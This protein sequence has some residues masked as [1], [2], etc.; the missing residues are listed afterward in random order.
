MLG[1]PVHGIVAL[2]TGRPHE[3]PGPFRSHQIHDGD[4]YELRDGHAVH[5]MTASE[6]HG[7][8]NLVGGRVLASDPAVAGSVGVDVGFSFNDGKNLRAP[9]ISTGVG[10]QP[11]WMR[12]AP[13]LAVEY[14]GPGQDEVE[15]Q[16]KIHE[17]LAAG[18]RYLWVV[19]LTGPLRV[20]VYTPGEPLRVVDGDGI[21]TAPGVLA[22]PVPVRS[23][24]DERA[25][26]EVMF[27][28]LLAAH[29]YDGLDAVREE[30]REEGR[31]EGERQAQIRSIET[32]L[33]ARGLSMTPAQL[34]RLRACSDADV[35][36]RWLVRSAAATSV[37]A[38][39][40]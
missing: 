23:L 34:A 12:T 26:D 31:V 16:A 4:P 5:C 24:V 21:L 18:T 2:V 17:L 14:A 10:D 3:A 20:E 32:I 39:V 30:G 36:T 35:L 25:A 22:N 33:H 38:A 19:R 11:G 29:G 13:P 27:R 9:D 15:M 1:A 28:N 40:D 7:R 6:R 37:D 8:A